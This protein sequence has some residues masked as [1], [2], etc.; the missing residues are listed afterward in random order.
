MSDGIKHWGKYRGTVVNNLDPMR[1]GRLQAIVPDV[2][3]EIPCSWA[4]VCTPWAGIQMGMFV[5]PQI[6]SGVWI[7][8]ENG[9][10]DRPIWSG[11]WYGSAAD[12]PALA[13]TI[14]P[15]MTGAVLQSQSQSAIMISDLPGPAGGILI[16]HMAGAL[17][18]ISEAG[19]T[20]SNG[21]G[22]TITMIGPTVTINSGA[23]TVI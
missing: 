11:M 8:F 5:V 15:P 20:I 23:L 13:N 18:S 3:G 21:Q 9:D 16:K 1:Q 22:A 14:V 17:I 10:S 4:M 6:G 12:V 2:L 19:I 7:E